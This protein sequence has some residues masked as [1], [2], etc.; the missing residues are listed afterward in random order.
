MKVYIVGEKNLNLENTISTYGSFDFINIKNNDDLI[1]KI[2]F[3]HVPFVCFLS[4]KSLLNFDFSSILQKNSEQYN[5]LVSTIVPKIENPDFL[6]KK[7]LI[8]FLYTDTLGDSN[9]P[10]G[11]KNSGIYLINNG[12][13]FKKHLEID[14]ECTLKD[15]RILPVYTFCKNVNSDDREAVLFLDRDGIINEDTGYLY[16]IEDL[17]FVD[18]IFDLIKIANLH[19]LKVVVVTNQSGVGRGYYTES[20]VNKLHEY[21]NQEITK[22]G[23]NV[24]MWNY[25]IFHPEAEDITL[26]G[27]S[28]H[29]KPFPGMILDAGSKLAINFDNSI[30]VGDKKS[31]YILGD[32][33]GKTFHLEGNYDLAGAKGDIVLNLS[34]IKTY[35][36]NNY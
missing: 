15:F 3:N 27:D 18:G 35:I 2:D 30:M 33:I 7:D 21:M 20:D 28:F 24:T 6:A 29:R 5:F 34:Q 19:N 1:K 17:K 25:C 8:P 16:K 11:F 26:K 22:N 23:G 14:N 32:L 13:A 12:N 31:D 36:K 4:S 10:E 9:F